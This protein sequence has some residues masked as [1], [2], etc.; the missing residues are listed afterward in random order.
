MEILEIITIGWPYCGFKILAGL[1]ALSLGTPCP[2]VLGALL[3]ALGAVDLVINTANLVSLFVT[4][5]RMSAVCLFCVLSSRIGARWNF[6][7]RAL[8]EVGE[9]LDTMTAFVLVAG[10]VGFG[11][12]GQ[13]PPQQRSIWG[14]C[15]VLNVMGAG[16]ARLGRSL[17]K[18]SA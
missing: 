8:L 5:K 1:W 3:L 4:Q 9:S 11:L 10:G 17:R 16:L 13:L 6:P 12:I 18:L 14:A 7:E 2:F 15:T